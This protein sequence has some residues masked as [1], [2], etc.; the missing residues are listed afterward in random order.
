[1]ELTPKVRKPGDRNLLR[2]ASSLS[3]VT[4]NLFRILSI[5]A[6]CFAAGEEARRTGTVVQKLLL[7]QSLL[8]D[9]STQLQL[10]S[11]QLLINKVEFSAGG[12]FPVNLSLACSMVGAATT[13][14]IILLQFMRFLAV[15]NNI[16]T[17]IFFSTYVTLTRTLNSVGVG[18]KYGSIPQHDIVIF[19]NVVKF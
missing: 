12:F 17:P 16:C 5:T 4:Q 2:G 3:W 6:S 1:M 15:S 8:R 10:F 19:P 7:R 11:L 13:Y 9:T 14:I 18:Q